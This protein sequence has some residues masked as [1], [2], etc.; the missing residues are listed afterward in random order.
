MSDIKND[1]LKD[2]KILDI[3]SAIRISA[4]HPGTKNKLVRDY[5][6]SW[7]LIIKTEG[8]TKYET[9]ARTY[10]IDKNH[11]IILPKGSSYSR[12][13]IE[14][15]ECLVLEFQALQE[16][17]NLILLEMTDRSKVYSLFN[18]IERRLV[19]KPPLHYLKNLRDLYDILTILL[20][21]TEHEYMP[22]SKYDILTP[23][24]T[25]IQEHYSERDIKNEKLA[26]MCGIGN[27][28]F[29]AL[30]KQH[31]NQSPIAYLNMQRIERAKELLRSGLV[32]VSQVAGSV[33]CSNPY[34]FSRVFKK[35]TGLSPTDFLKQQNRKEVF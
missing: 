33:G 15:G 7:A 1:I 35:Y 8:Q 14:Q 25:Y 13:Y 24:I 34:Y 10:T 20:S 2:I 3:Y 30:F 31:L 9:K 19:Q 17:E 5:R 6:N 23:A 27:A 22:S 32:S 26:A 18:K 4:E 28:H 29:R 16:Y 11:P 12:T 21:P